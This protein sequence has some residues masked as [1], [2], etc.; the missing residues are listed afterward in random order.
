MEIIL[1]CSQYWKMH[2]GIKQ[3][4]WNLETEIMNKRIENM[5]KLSK[6]KK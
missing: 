2:E 6:T 5:G 4:I 3:E 1:Y